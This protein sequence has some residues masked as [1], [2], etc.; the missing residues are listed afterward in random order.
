M[1]VISIN[2]V[3]YLIK[4]ED[5]ERPYFFFKKAH[6]FNRLPHDEFL[7]WSKIQ[8]MYADGTRNVSEN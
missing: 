5:A 4:F 3:K 7:D 2:F 1:K 8:S 6:V